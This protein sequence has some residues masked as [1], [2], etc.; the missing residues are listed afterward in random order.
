LAGLAGPA[1]NAPAKPITTAATAIIH[2]FILSLTSLLFFQTARQS[3]AALGNPPG[4][5]GS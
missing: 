4:V 2:F 1:R 3:S 5:L